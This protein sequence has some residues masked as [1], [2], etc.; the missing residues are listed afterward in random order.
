MRRGEVWWVDFAPAIGGEIQK[1]RPTVIVSNNAANL[2]SN[3]VQVIPL[4]TK[5]N[6]VYPSDAK[7][8]VQERESKA[9]A[10]QIRTVAKERLGTFIGELTPNDLRKVELAIRIQ[11]GLAV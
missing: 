9:M 1:S 10:D 3:R 11:L 4:S 6:R 2:H 8:I 7:I 5:T